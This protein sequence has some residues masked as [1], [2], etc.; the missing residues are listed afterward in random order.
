MRLAVGTIDQAMVGSLSRGETEPLVVEWLGLGGVHAKWHKCA[1]GAR[2][3][4]GLLLGHPRVEPEA[5]SVCAM[6]AK[7]YID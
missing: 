1:I 7:T 3:E 2:A 6:K 5:R 4:M